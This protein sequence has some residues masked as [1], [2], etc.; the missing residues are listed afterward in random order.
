MN[1]EYRLAPEHPFPVSIDDACTVTRWVIDH[2]TVVGK[3]ASLLNYYRTRLLQN[4]SQLVAVEL[5]KTDL[6]CKPTFTAKFDAQRQKQWKCA[7]PHKSRQVGLTPTVRFWS[8]TP[9]W[10][11]RAANNAAILW[12]SFKSRPTRAL[13]PVATCRRSPYLHKPAI[14]IMTSFS[15]WRHSRVSRL[16]HS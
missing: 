8:N 1:V 2:K 6:W 7:P 10:L 11:C 9:P 12:F 5:L 4:S 3:L 16:R 15:L 14:I 13:Q